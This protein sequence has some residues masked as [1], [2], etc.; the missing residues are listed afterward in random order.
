MN[1][2]KHLMRDMMATGVE[3]ISVIYY[4]ITSETL[5]KEKFKKNF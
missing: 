4:R 5:P 2:L 1:L 3:P